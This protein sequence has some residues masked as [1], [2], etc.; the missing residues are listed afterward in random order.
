LYEGPG[1]GGC[2]WP[3]ELTGSC[4]RPDVA[5]EG[6]PLEFASSTRC[7]DDPTQ[8]WYGVV[9]FENSAVCWNHVNTLT[10][11]RCVRGVPT[12]SQICAR[13]GNCLP[14]ETRRCL[15][16]NLKIGAQV[17]ADEGDCW[18]ACEGTS[19]MEKPAKK[20]V[21]PSCDQINLTINLPEELTM[22]PAQIMAFLYERDTWTFP[23][24]RPPDGG[25]SECQILEPDIKYG[26]PY[27]M[28]VPACTYYRKKCLKGEYMLYVALMQT[29]I[30]P[31]IMLEGDSWWG[32]DQEPLVLGGTTGQQIDLEINLVKYVAE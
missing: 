20:D 26:T 9:M 30:N 21:C 3:E 19:F 17:C 7:P 11:V 24:N 28:T 29:E 23:P 32:M 31:P 10:D 27:T 16:N 4:S 1:I 12:S 25:N 22:E 14:G 15:A 13:K 5:S 8:D 6:H 2:Y 18:G